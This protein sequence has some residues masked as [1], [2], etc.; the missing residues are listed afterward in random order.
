MLPHLPH[1]LAPTDPRVHELI[2]ERWSPRAFSDREVSWQDL[3]VLF[4]AAEWAASSFNEQ[5]WRFIV[6]TRADQPNWNK[7]LECLVEAN[8]TWA[9]NAPVLMLTAAK[10]T[11]SQ[12]GK[13]NYHALHDTGMALAHLMLQATFMGL[14][15][16]S[17]AGFHHD[18]SRAAFSIPEDYDLGAAVAVGYPGDPAS[19]PPRLQAAEVAPR[20]RKPLSDFVF[21]G[22]WGEL[23]VAG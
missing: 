16:H 4:E 18:K 12:T 15:A 10:R 22:V 13:P 20:T 7:L 11:F 17:M 6:A 19:L 3:R 23:R 9:R 1:K 14:A 21:T 2:R 5:P 8:Q